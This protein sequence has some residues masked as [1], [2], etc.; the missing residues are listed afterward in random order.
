M[1]SVKQGG[2]HGVGEAGWWP[3]FAL[4]AVGSLVDFS[5]GALLIRYM[6]MTPLP[7]FQRKSG[8]DLDDER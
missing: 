6:R 4:F 8:V 2:G 5:G 7:S 3:W 1:V